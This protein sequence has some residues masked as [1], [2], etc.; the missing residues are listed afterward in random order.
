MRVACWRVKAA[1]THSEYVIIIAFQWQKWLRTRAS[2]LRYSTLPVLWISAL[3][4]GQQ[5]ASRFG[6]I[7][8]RGNSSG[9][10]RLGGSQNAAGGGDEDKTPLLLSRIES[11]LSET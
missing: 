2:V 6:P 4:Q 1:D 3:N 9:I 8:S 5:L 7:Y 10:R 11:R